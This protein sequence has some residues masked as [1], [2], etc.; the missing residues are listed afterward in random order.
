LSTETRA[1]GAAPEPEHNSAWRGHTMTTRRQ[2]ADC[3]LHT[4]NPENE[5]FLKNGKIKI[6]STSL[7]LRGEMLVLSTI[8]DNEQDEK[9][10]E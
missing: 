10:R 7:L 4:E 9:G 6:Y 3:A 2:T 1:Q 5:L 8:N